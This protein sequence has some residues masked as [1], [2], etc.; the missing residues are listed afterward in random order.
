MWKCSGTVSRN[1]HEDEETRLERKYG[2]Q[3][4]GIEESKGNIIVGRR[5]L[6]KIWENYITELYDQSK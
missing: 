1:E 2:I 4:I 6:L 5:Q 3:N